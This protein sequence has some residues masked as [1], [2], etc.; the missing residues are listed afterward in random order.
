MCGRSVRSFPA[1]RPAAW[2]I[3]GDTAYGTN[4][5]CVKYGESV[6]MA[7]SASVNSQTGEVVAD[8][9]V[10]IE[11]GN[12]IWTGEHI[13]YNFKTHQMQSE[14]FRTGKPPVFTQGRQ[15]QG[16]TTNKT[17]TRATRFRH[18]R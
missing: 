15:L 14:Q 1:R 5:I 2:T 16:D 4:G 17:Y 12:L 10:R 18:D 11:E 13:R 6:L 3:V 7:D 8:G 9:N